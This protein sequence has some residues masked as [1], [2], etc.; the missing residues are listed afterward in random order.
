MARDTDPFFINFIKVSD[1]KLH[2]VAVYQ[3]MDYYYSMADSATAGASRGKSIECQWS[4]EVKCLI[5]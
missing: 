3:W 5:I 4:I 1:L 2:I